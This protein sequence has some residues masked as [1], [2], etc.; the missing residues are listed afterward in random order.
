MY[1]IIAECTS[2][3]STSAIG[4]RQDGDEVGLLCRHWSARGYI[5]SERM[6]DCPKVIN[7]HEADA[8]A[9]TVEQ[10]QKPV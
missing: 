1:P 7:V 9:G 10:E 4:N 5:L 6:N 8:S 3:D 2:H